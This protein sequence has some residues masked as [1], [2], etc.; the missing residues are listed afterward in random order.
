MHISS[1]IVQVW[2]DK[3]VCWMGEKESFSIRLTLT[4]KWD[5]AIEKKIITNKLCVFFFFFSSLLSIFCRFV[6]L[7]L[8]LRKMCKETHR[9]R[10]KLRLFCK[11]DWTIAPA[12]LQLWE[13]F[14]LTL[15][16]RQWDKLWESSRVASHCGF[17]CRRIL[18]D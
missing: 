5:F 2:W 6:L 9:P 13:L 12:H 11:I 8:I 7:N 10:H 18:F 16:I 14:E 17:T 15:M 4:E 1:W 3:F